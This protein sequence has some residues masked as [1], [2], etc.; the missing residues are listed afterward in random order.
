VY[1][2][3]GILDKV[4]VEFRIGGTGIR[5]SE[6]KNDQKMNQLDF[7]QFSKRRISIW[8]FWN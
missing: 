8:E 1:D 2:K 4:I 3:G 7:H 6:Y 5:L